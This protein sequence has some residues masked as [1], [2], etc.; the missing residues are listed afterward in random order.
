MLPHSFPKLS[1]PLTPNPGKDDT[2]NEKI[3]GPLSLPS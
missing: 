2:Q 3:I 1:S